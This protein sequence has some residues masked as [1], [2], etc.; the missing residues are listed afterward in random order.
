MAVTITSKPAAGTDDGS[1][2]NN[3]VGSFSTSAT[4]IRIGDSATTDDYNRS[5]WVRFPGIVVPVGATITSA[6]IEVH[7]AGLTGAIPQMK[8]DANAADNP[9]APASR[10]AVNAMVHTTANATWT[11]STWATPTPYTSPELKTVIQ[12]LINRPGWASG[13]AILMFFNDVNTANVLGQLTFTSF[14]GSTVDCATLSV[15]YNTSTPPTADAG[16]DQTVGQSTT[17]T[18]HGSG[19]TVNGSITGYQW[20]Q[21]SGASV[22]LSSATAQEPTFTAPGTSGALVF[23]LVVTDSASLQSNQDTVTITV[24]GAAPTANAGPD[25][26]NVEPLTT[27]TLTGA[28]STGSPSVWQWRQISGPSVTLSS[29]SVV[30]PT[31]TSPATTDGATLTFGLKVGDGVVLS[32]ED[33]VDIQVLPQITWIIRGGVPVPYVEKVRQAGNWV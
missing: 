31:F 29:T 17:V 12:E 20:T 21:L 3:G 23:G 5:G 26:A 32:D 24:G 18:L 7:A 4:V 25:Q 30:S 13:N 16:S 1:W 19:S 9:A 27:T 33:T 2:H 22:G 6:T 11:P 14:E 28:G 15:S 10:S 8:I